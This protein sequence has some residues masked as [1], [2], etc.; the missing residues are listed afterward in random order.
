MDVS[1]TAEKVIDVVRQHYFSPLGAI[2]LF[3][4][5]NCNCRCDY[6]FVGKKRTSQMSE[7]TM[8]RGINFLFRESANRPQLE[9][10]FFGGEP[11][12][13]FDLLRKGVEHA[14]AL[15]KF[16]RKRVGF[17]VT[18]NGTLL[19][20]EICKY[21][22]QHEIAPLI[23]L[24]GSKRNHNRHRKYPD[25]RGTFDSVVRGIE[26]MRATYG[27]AGVRVTVSPEAV[28]DV[29]SDIRWMYEDFGVYSFIINVNSCAD[30][31][32][33]AIRDYNEQMTAINEFF[34]SE[35]R[36]GRGFTLR[37]N[38]TVASF[39]DSGGKGRPC[40]AGLTQ[41]TVYIDG[42]LYPCSRLVDYDE[43]V[44]GHCDSGR[45][46]TPMLKKILLFD[47]ERKQQ[48]DVCSI[49]NYCRGG[50]FAIN[51]ENTGSISLM[52]GFECIR[53]AHLYG[54]LLANR[55]LLRLSRGEPATGH[56]SLC[57]A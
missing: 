37:E 52:P 54:S 34:L 30:W 26:N 16:Y 31:S 7:E 32:S 49:N 11:L 18:T 45:T 38:L 27:W 15:G 51:F 33:E 12:M 8:L 50:C 48:C 25:G 29:F 13:A 24:D 35:T 23:S 3:L 21:L 17:G 28:K 44:M 5:H 42:R 39:I 4:T 57:L 56:T 10:I 9:I 2:D 41:V 19:T 43:F 22:Q 6:C 20:R 40:P 55:E 36:N 46:L 14:E 53:N 1:K 47:K